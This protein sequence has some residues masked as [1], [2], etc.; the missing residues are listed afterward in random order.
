MKHIKHHH[1]SAKQQHRHVA[2]LQRKWASDASRDEKYNRGRAKQER[3]A[4]NSVLAR[5]YSKE[6]K[7]DHMWAGRRR[8]IANK[9][10]KKGK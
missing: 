7:A 1:M 8:G 6:A 3:K 10:A 4:G 5:G 9:E 2:K